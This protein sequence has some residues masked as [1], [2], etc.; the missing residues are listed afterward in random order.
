MCE[1]GGPKLWP[2]LAR[3][4]SDVDDARCHRR[5]CVADRSSVPVAPA[6]VQT[7]S[8]SGPCR[9][10][11]ARPPLDFGSL[12]GPSGDGLP[13]QGLGARDRDLVRDLQL[14]PRGLQRHGRPARV[15]NGAARSRDSWPQI[16][17][18]RDPGLLA[19]RA[20]G[21]EEILRIMAAKSH[22]TRS[23]ASR[24]LEIPLGAILGHIPLTQIGW[25]QNV[26]HPHNLHRLRF[27]TTID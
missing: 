6:L 10:A 2:E 20:A 4:G 22:L 3:Q 17:S 23:I 19:G 16:N 25:K 7:R 21:G 12:V 14:Q 24:K 27:R 26:L 15:R 5:P 11:F 18:V 13:S 1:M 9:L 8:L